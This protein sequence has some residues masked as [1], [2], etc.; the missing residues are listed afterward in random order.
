MRP[1]FCILAFFMIASSCSREQDGTTVIGD[2]ELAG[3]WQLQTLSASTQ[4]LGFPQSFT[5]ENAQGSFQFNADLT[6]EVDY[7]VKLFGFSFAKH[8]DFTYEKAIPNVFI[9]HS[10]GTIDQWDL[11]ESRDGY[12]DAEWDVDINGIPARLKAIIIK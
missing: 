12:I 2:F 9:Y 5:D 11:M 3:E 10:D 4:A 6:G 7:N 1:L 8:V